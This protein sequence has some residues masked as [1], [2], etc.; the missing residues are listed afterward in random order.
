[1]LNLGV[2]WAHTGRVRALAA[3]DFTTVAPGFDFGKGLGDLPDSLAWARPFAMTG[4]VAYEFPTKSQSAGMP[5]PNNF[6]YGFAVEYSLPYLEC[7]VR[8]VGLRRPWNQLIPLVE[9]ALT[10]PV[11]HTAF[12]G[13]TTTGTIQPGVIWSG[14]YMQIGAE[15]IIP[16]NA[17]SGH[18]LGGIIQLHF[19]L[20]DLFPQGLGRPIS[21]W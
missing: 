18:G 16:V 6:D 8:D 12:P 10:M 3:D 14:H 20:D 4:N 19:Y 15:M 11:N 2:S 13:V 1:M 5:L 21:E 7:C 9:V 17:A